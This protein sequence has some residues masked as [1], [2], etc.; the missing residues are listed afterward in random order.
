MRYLESLCV[1]RFNV[2]RLGTNVPREKVAA[3]I[4]AAYRCKGI[5][6]SAG[7]I[8]E[9]A[10]E[11]TLEANGDVSQMITDPNISWHEEIW[12]ISA[13]RITG[14]CP[15][16]NDPYEINSMIAQCGKR[17][18]D[19]AGEIRQ[20]PVVIQND[21]G[22]NPQPIRDLLPLLGI[23]GKLNNH[24][25]DGHHRTILAV[26]QGRTQMQCLTAYR[27]RALL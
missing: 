20:C 22:Y 7:N 8:L 11:L 23:R 3:V 16:R 6:P 2:T 10:V 24:I 4:V 1:P 13:L 19:F 12:P 27:R 21:I 17:F 26:W 25:I 9:Q 15:P 14:M 18:V 5:Y